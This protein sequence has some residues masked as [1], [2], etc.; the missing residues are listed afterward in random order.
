MLQ[1]GS[2][3]SQTGMG[4]PCNPAL[5]CEAEKATEYVPNKTRVRATRR[6]TRFICFFSRN[7]D[8]TGRRPGGDRG[9]GSKVYPWVSFRQTGKRTIY[10]LDTAK[11]SR[12]V[13]R[14]TACPFGVQ[15]NRLLA[16]GRPPPLP[17]SHGPVPG[18]HRT[19]PRLPGRLSGPTAAGPDGS[20]PRPG[21]GPWPGR[22]RRHAPHG[23]PAP[24]ATGC[25]GGRGLR[26]RHIAWP[27]SRG[28]P[29]AVEKR[30]RAAVRRPL[31]STGQVR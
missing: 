22:Q 24:A 25:W 18:R 2:P 20:G 7:L 15:A 3:G 12:V 23:H 19:L 10:Q 14:L 13:F 17:S 1:L 11:R 4:E 31:K 27:H 28:R 5:V 29:A 8:L 16:S 6:K 30:K 21:Y 26:G 9:A